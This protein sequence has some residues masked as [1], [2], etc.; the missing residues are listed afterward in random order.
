MQK[1]EYKSIPIIRSYAG[2]VAHEPQLNKLGAEGW[3]LIAIV[4]ACEGNAG[5]TVFKRPL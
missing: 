3:E 1:W 5:T 2:V 4:S